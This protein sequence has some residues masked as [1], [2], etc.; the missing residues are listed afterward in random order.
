MDDLAEF[1]KHKKTEEKSGKTQLKNIREKWV[2][3]IHSLFQTILEWIKKAE[4]EKLINVYKHNIQLSE[5][6]IGRYA[7]DK[8]ELIVLDRQIIIEPIAR[9]I[10]GCDGRVDI[11]HG[12]ENFRLLYS[13]K[14]DS[15]QIEDRKDQGY[16]KP[17]TRENFIELLKVLV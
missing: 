2:G 14:N 17:L 13:G 6:N 7:V 8:L 15:W 3:T 1:L 16:R 9:F 5:K 4:D 10:E 11:Y 12:Y